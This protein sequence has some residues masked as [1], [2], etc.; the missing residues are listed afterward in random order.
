M[1]TN[2]SC[3]RCGAYKCDNSLYYAIKRGKRVFKGHSFEMPE[4]GEN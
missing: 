3:P 4:R 1:K 2:T